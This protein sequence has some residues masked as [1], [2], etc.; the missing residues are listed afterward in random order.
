M[1]KKQYGRCVICQELF[2]PMDVIKADRIVTKLKRGSDKLE[3][4]QAIHK[5]CHIQKSLLYFT[6]SIDSFSVV[7]S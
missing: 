5:H 2:L 6:A 4:L 1:I 7:G 3:N